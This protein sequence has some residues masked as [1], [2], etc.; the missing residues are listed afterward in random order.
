MRTSPPHSV[1]KPTTT[2]PAPPVDGKEK[3]PLVPLLT[4]IFILKAAIKEVPSRLVKRKIS[5]EEAKGQ[6]LK[7]QTEL[8]KLRACMQAAEVQLKKALENL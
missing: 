3:S 5:A 1:S 8:Q 7:M 2:P 6:L 4:E